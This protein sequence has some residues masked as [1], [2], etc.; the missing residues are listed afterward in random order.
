MGAPEPTWREGY[1][2][3][4]PGVVGGEPCI[5]GT[6]VTVRAIVEMRRRGVLP[7]EIP[8]HIP[9]ITLAQVYSALAYFADHQAEILA[10]IEANRV[11]VGLAH[12]ATLAKGR[13]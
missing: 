2:S 8:G 4:R 11:P 7:E 10:H 5:D 3:S 12:P 6:R 1:I 9:H 13:A